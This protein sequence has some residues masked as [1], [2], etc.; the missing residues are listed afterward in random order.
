VGNWSD[1]D[2]ISVCILKLTE[3]AKAFYNTTS[4]LQ[5]PDVTW[6]NFAE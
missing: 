2:K 6:E 1:A 3:A 4:E 5:E